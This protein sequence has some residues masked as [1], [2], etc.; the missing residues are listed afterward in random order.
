[1]AHREQLRR[2]RLQEQHF[3]LYPAVTSLGTPYDVENGNMVG[4]TR[5]GFDDLMAQD[6]GAIWNPSAD[7]GKG[8]ITGSSF[9]DWRDSPRVIPIALF[10]PHQIAGIQSGGSL[11]LTFNK[12]ALFFVEGFIGNG[13][14]A[15]LRGR[16]L[17][18]ATGS[19]TGPTVGPLTKILQ[20]V[21]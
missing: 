17:Y 4:P 16:F 18:Y 11:S 20:L 9:R 8:G 12:F 6:P 5:Q 13:N 1:M 15:P 3:E 10:D 19:G 21:Q 14:Q 2:Q 7:N